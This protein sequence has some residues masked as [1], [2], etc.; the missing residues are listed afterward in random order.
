MVLPQDPSTNPY[1][2]RPSRVARASHG[3][4]PRPRPPTPSTGRVC[5]HRRSLG[6][7]SNRA[8]MSTFS[9]PR[10]EKNPLWRAIPHF[11]RKRTRHHTRIR[12]GYPDS[13]HVIGWCSTTTKS[14]KKKEAG[15]NFQTRGRP[16]FPSPAARPPARR[17]P[18]STRAPEAAACG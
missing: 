3:A 5:S 1:S 16:G 12:K 11:G 8:W 9:P 15:F 13:K 4:A 17:P 18:R 2:H 6:Q 7:N 10:L 14:V